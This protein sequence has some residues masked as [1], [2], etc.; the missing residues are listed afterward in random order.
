MVRAG[1]QYVGL[2][3][4]R[5]SASLAF[6]PHAQLQ[7]RYVQDRHMHPP[8]RRLRVPRRQRFCGAVAV[9]EVT[10]CHSSIN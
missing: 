3:A 1:D 7:V 10:L 9:R 4:P 6:G 8:P 5:S 2:R